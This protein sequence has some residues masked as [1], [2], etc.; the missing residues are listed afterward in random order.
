MGKG[1][2]IR[3]TIIYIFFYMY[4]LSSF[5]VHNGIPVNKSSNIWKSVVKVGQCTGSIVGENLI[6]TAAHCITDEYHDTFNIYF[7]SGTEISF[8][9]L[10]SKKKETIAI[11]GGKFLPY[12]KHHVGEDFILLEVPG[13]LDRARAE[14]GTDDYKPLNLNRFDRSNKNEL[15][16]AGVNSSNFS[17]GV[18]YFDVS[19]YYEGNRSLEVYSTNKRSAMCQGDSG[20]PLLHVDSSSGE[21]SLYGI[22]VYIYS[23]SS[24]YKV[25]P[26]YA[27]EKVICSTRGLEFTK[28]NNDVLSEILL[29]KELT[30]DRNAL[31]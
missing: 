13:L 9:I 3:I 27:S 10:V 2:N 22:A 18:S 26:K 21:M 5:G 30:Q 16:L 28:M 31:E 29:I 15:I 7:Y 4:S 8:S 20:G 12:K 25:K 17:H 11:G 14:S 23:N 24:W 6:A 19:L 1:I